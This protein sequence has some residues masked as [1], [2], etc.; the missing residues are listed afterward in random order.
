VPRGLYE[1]LKKGLFRSRSAEILWNVRDHMGRTWKRVVKAVAL[2]APG[3]RPAVSAISEGYQFEACYCYSIDD[4]LV[5]DLSV[6][7]PYKGNV[8]SIVKAWP[9]WVGGEEGTFT[10]CVEILSG[11]EGIDNP[12][13]LC[14][15]LHKQAQGKWPAEKVHEHYQ[16]TEEELSVAS[17]AVGAV[18]SYIGSQQTTNSER[19]ETEMPESGQPATLFKRY[20]VSTEAE[21]EAKIKEFETEAEKAKRYEAT[22][23]QAR[24]D[25]IREFVTGQVAAGRLYPKMQSDAVDVL[26]KLDE[27]GMDGEVKKFQAILGALPNLIDLSERARAGG[28]DLYRDDEGEIKNPALEVDVKAKAYMAEGKA[29]D[30]KSAMGLVRRDHPRLWTAYAGVRR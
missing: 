18:L 24:Q 17:V 25:K 2:L 11:K 26:L 1:L 4:G 22:I 28:H 15:W 14:A 29:K 21:L 13:A 19:E 7:K 3:Q 20:G 8:E 30:Y 23:K 5:E 16:P 12:E 10:R 9:Q 6:T 27:A